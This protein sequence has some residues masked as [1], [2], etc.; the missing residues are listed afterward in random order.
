MT[1]AVDFEAP[2]WG[3]NGAGG[4]TVIRLPFDAKAIFGRTRCPVRVTVNEHTWRTTTQVQGGQFHVVVSAAS[5]RAA[6]IQAGDRVQVTVRKDEATRPVAIPVELADAL[7]A[8]PEAREAFEALAP[9][10]RREYARWVAEASLPQTRERRSVA[11]VERLR[12]AVRR[13]A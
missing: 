5:R 13:P 10:H 3:G 4:Q 8:A 6:G 1:D 9:S 12:S 7:C 2:I 11:A